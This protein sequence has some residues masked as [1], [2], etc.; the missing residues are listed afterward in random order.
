MWEVART[1]EQI[2]GLGAAAVKALGRFMGT[3]EELRAI[4]GLPGDD[5]GAGEDEDRTARAGD[6]SGQVPIAE[7]L[8]AMLAQTGYVEA[9]EAERTIE[10][11]G[12]IENLEQLV[13]VGREFDAAAAE[14]ENALDVFLQQ[15]ALVA[16][17]D[18]RSDDEGLV[19]LMTLHNAKGLEYPIVFIAGCEEGVFPHSRAIEE[20]A[21]EEERRLF[22][23][24]ITRAMRQ[25]YL[26]YARRRAV[27][28][29]A[30]YG[31]R[32]RFLDEIPPDLL[33]EHEERAFRPGVS[34]SGTGSSRHRDGA[35][36][37][38]TG[39]LG[40]PVERGSLGGERGAG[41]RVAR[42]PVPP[43]RGRRARG[44]RRRRRDGRGAGRS[45]RRALR[46]RRLGA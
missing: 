10:A 43:G 46:R 35:P 8:E 12:R 22:Y 32:S 9:L 20:G 34:W 33:E 1:P 21:L 6:G 39:Q 7:L 30:T 40:R 2:P 19:T 31:M 11:Q 26:T 25:L 14:G 37:L 27:F 41:A 5:R 24:G 16:D 17:A 15:I 18:T 3:M 42:Q 4:A 28:G 38:H 45:D 23:V 13:E 29:A 44:L 36:R